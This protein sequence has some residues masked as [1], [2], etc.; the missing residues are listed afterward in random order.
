MKNICD[1]TLA[2]LF[3]FTSKSNMWSDSCDSLSKS[4]LDNDIDGY[5]FEPK[6]YDALL[7][8]RGRGSG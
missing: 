1:T 7:S 4:E 8:I 2:S 5:M 3:L 6:R